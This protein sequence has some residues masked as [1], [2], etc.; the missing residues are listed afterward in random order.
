MGGWIGQ[1]PMQRQKNTGIIIMKPSPYQIESRASRIP[2]RR[3]VLDVKRRNDK[4]QVG[5]PIVYAK[6][7][8]AK[9]ATPARA[10]GAWS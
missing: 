2:R 4:R 6:R 8:M 9:A 1:S 7:A 10:T 3:G 5:V